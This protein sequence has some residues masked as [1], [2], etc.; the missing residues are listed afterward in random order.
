MEQAQ[1]AEA[2]R[3]SPGV[4]RLAVAQGA[5]YVAT[6]VWPLVHLRSFELVTGPKPEGWLVKTVG[7]LVTVIGG[8]LLSAGRRR[9]VAPEVAMLAVGS[10]VSLAAVDVLSVARRRISPVYLLDAVAEVALAVG[11]ALSLAGR[12]AG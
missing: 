10:A 3:C 1:H 12:R 11:W 4:A 2:E 8:A 7:A 6:G 9:R 5:F